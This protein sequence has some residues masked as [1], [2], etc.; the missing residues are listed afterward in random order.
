MDG[1]SS[2][3][4]KKLIHG[5]MAVMEDI[6]NMFLGQVFSYYMSYVIDQEQ[7]YEINQETF[8]YFW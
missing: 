5:D 2:S 6:Y 1:L 4:V 3:D 7:G 8:V